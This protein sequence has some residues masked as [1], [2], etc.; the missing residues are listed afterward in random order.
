MSKE[1]MLGEQENDA[2]LYATAKTFNESVS[3]GNVNVK[4]GGD[5]DPE[6]VVSDEVPF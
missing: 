5:A 1:R 3:E 4:H 6:P 2:A